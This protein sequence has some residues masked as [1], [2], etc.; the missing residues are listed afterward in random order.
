[1]TASGR[2]GVWLRIGVVLVGLGIGLASGSGVR[3]A[4]TILV[5]G[6]DDMSVDRQN[7]QAAVDAAP[8]GGTIH[9]SGEFQL[10]GW[11]VLIHRSNLTIAGVSHG[12]APAVLK[13]WLGPLGNPIGDVALNTPNAVLHF[14]RGFAITSVGGGAIEGITLRDFSMT[15]FNRAIAVQSFWAMTNLCTAP[16]VGV[17]AAD[18]RIEHL[19]I[20]HVVRGI[21]TFG[22][23][24]D[25][26][27]MNTEVTGAISDG[28]LLNSGAV[29][30]VNADGTSGTFSVGSLTGAE[31][32]HDHVAMVGT[33]A[34]PQAFN[35]VGPNVD[36]LVMGNTFEGGAA[37]AHLN[38]AVE[39]FVV[40]NN[41]IINGGTQGAANA[42]YGG[43]RMTAA[44]GYVLT[45][46]SFSGNVAS[47]TLPSTTLVP[48]DIWL[49]GAT[50][51]NSLT[52][53][54]STIVV[55]EGTG[56]NITVRGQ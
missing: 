29:A 9:L 48:R 25:L 36:V 20:D 12:H 41:T 11:P 21:Q 51:G 46:N 43:I 30:C 10:D 7:L 34:L 40:R 19:V 4:Q 45:N 23:V 44:S 26:R 24:R 33:A 39:N 52:V 38:G 42:R 6:L 56:N 31:L 15:G 27:V 3:A 32:R 54:R 8:D 50:T 2:R 1:M 13:G 5:V 49:F 18:I 53:G 16:N 28:I 17:E 35:A 47:Q 14:N 55:D 37:A 22:T